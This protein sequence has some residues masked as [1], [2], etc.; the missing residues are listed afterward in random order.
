MGSHLAAVEIDVCE[1][2]VELEIVRE[3]TLSGARRASDQQEPPAAA[4]GFAR[5]TGY[6]AESRHSVR[7]PF[8]RYH[9]GSGKATK[10]TV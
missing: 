5:K 10:T 1:A 8:R 6:V 7:A 4:P 3:R 9:G 2:A